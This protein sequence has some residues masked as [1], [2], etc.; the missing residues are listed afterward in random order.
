MPVG[1]SGTLS[2][3]TLKISPQAHATRKMVCL[4][5]K[6]QFKSSRPLSELSGSSP[7]HATSG[8]YFTLE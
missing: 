7:I 5:R 3:E 4:W 1:S 8:C 2:A 6:I